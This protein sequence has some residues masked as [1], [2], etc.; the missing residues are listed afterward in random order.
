MAMFIKIATVVFVWLLLLLLLLFRLRCKLLLLTNLIVVV[1][2]ILCY[3]GINIFNVRRWRTRR[4]KNGFL[5][6]FDAF[7]WIMFVVG[8]H[9]TYF[10]VCWL[11]NSCRR[12][13]M[14]YLRHISLTKNCYWSRPR[15]HG[16]TRRF[17]NFSS[18]IA[19]DINRRI[20]SIFLS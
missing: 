2:C 16:I 4:W 6:E 15:R 1:K 7:I 17:L 5:R 3:F 20:Q 18:K 13:G 12:F 11:N 19:N 10:M 8:G 9:S 14:F